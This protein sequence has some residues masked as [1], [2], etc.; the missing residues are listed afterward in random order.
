MGKKEE[1]FQEKLDQRNCSLLKPYRHTFTYSF[2]GSFVGPL[3]ASIEDLN[4]KAV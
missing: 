1:K 3:A 4:T 2:W